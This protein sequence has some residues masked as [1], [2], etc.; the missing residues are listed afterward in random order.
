LSR[1]GLTANS[2]ASNFSSHSP[3]SFR[4]TRIKADDAGVK[5]LGEEKKGAAVA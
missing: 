5:W 1:N 3:I 2:P 4:T